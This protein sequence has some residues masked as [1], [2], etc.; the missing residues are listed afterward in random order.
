MNRL[1][2]DIVKYIKDSP[3]SY[4]IQFYIN[5]GFETNRAI[6]KGWEEAYEELLE[7]MYRYEALKTTIVK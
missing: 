7:K 2:S 4:H 3:A 1:D 5:Q 6:R